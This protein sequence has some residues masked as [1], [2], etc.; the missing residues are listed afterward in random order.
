MIQWVKSGRAVMKKNVLFFI[1]VG[2]VAILTTG[3]GDPKLQKTELTIA[4]GSKSGVYY[5]IGETMVKVLEKDYPNTKIKIIETDGS[6][7]NLQLLK[8]GKVDLALVQN[9]IAY[10]AVNGEAMFNGEKIGNVQG[11]A[12]LFP[13]IVQFV[14]AKSTGIETLDDLAGHKIAVGS[15]DSGTFY[16]AQ[17]ILSAANA[18]N[19]L[20]HFYLNATSAMQELAMGSI[21]GFIYTSGMPN[22]SIVD[23]GRKMEI[24]LLPVS[25]EL[26]QK[27]VS[28]YSFYYP[29]TI[30]LNQYPGQTE[31]FQGLEINAILVC[32]DKLSEND[33][34]LV[35]KSVIANADE[36][37]KNHP[38]LSKM[39]KATL[40]HQ[41]SVKLAPGAYKAHSEIK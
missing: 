37:G 41:L 22:P 6:V 40:R 10:Y 3:C 20:D 31:E 33:Q 39:T 13:E 25:V 2:I 26:V 4:T 35:T 9:D 5:P 14:V 30:G 12:S 32:A 7:E 17:Q 34:Y 38:R 36:L 28:T 27:L 29:S 8:E 11:M 21:D 16:N 23:L 18:W 19:N 15:K 24:R 1:F